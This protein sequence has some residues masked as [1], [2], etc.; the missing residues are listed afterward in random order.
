LLVILIDSYYDARIH[1]YKILFNLHRTLKYSELHINIKYICLG[2]INIGGILHSEGIYCGNLAQPC[3]A[4]VG[5]VLYRHLYRDQIKKKLQSVDNSSISTLKY[6]PVMKWE[7]WSVVK[8]VHLER[9]HLWV[10]RS[11]TVTVVS[12]FSLRSYGTKSRCACSTTLLS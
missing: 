11:T 3:V 5:A 7:H 9:L 2:S 1:E 8:D 4:A 12:Y 6:C 10:C